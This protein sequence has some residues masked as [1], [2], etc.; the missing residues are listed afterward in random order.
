MVVF[1]E[2]KVPSDPPPEFAQ[3]IPDSQDEPDTYER[4]VYHVVEL[5]DHQNDPAW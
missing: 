3:V 1:H 2:E 5:L 4:Y